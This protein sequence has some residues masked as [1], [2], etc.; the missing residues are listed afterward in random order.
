[1][2]ARGG[3]EESG[4]GQREK[5]CMEVIKTQRSRDRVGTG[6]KGKGVIDARERE[7]LKTTQNTEAE[8]K[9]FSRD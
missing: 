7:I 5:L 8:T 4:E 2:T 9:R 6:N 1:M 3:G